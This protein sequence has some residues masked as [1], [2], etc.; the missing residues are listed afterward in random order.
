MTARSKIRYIALNQLVL[1]PT[2]V[3]KTP[4]TA[5]EDA[6]LEASIRAHGIKQNLIVHPTPIDNKG[7]YEVDAGG[8]RLKILQKLAAEGVIDADYPVPC[9]IESADDARETS[10]VENTIRA[11]MH[12]A[13]EFVAMAELIDG[14]MT[15]EDVAKRFGT[16]E[17]HVKQRLRLGKLAPELLDAYRAG[18]ISLDIVTA[19]TLGAD[20]QA[21]R[22]VWNQLKDNSYI[23][24]HTVKRL[25]TEKAVPLNS[26]LGLFVGREAYKA[27][28]GTIN[29]DLFS[30]D[31]E[32]LY[33]R[34]GPGPPPRDRKARS[35]GRRIAPA[36]GVDQSGPRPRIR[37]YGAIRA[38]TAAA[39]RNPGRPRR[40]NRAH[41]NPSR[42]TRRNRRRRLHR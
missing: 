13:D 12:P 38:G 2:N 24:S 7:L 16:S 19:F 26:D 33:G 28:G 4:A 3:R 39:G 20:H 14:G 41:R 36:M 23:Q 18:D 35:Q 25:L 8:R 40:R 37:L 11:A 22:A 6:A 42:R 15:I 5:A 27:A 17:R 32:R 21:Q 34:R 9:K 10:L 1:S 30:G 31:D 29:E